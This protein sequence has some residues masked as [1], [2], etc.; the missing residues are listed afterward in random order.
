MPTV[1]DAPP[2]SEA[3]ANV[4]RGASLR[5]GSEKILQAGIED[6]LTKAGFPVR[7]EVILAPKDRIDFLVGGVGIE[8][9][10]G[11]TLNDAIRQLHRYAASDKVSELLLVTSRLLL[12]RVP[13]ELDGKPVYAVY[14][15]APF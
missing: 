7:R 6:A 14:V 8:V 15:G 3:I 12:A 13:S 2:G 5:F 11:G 9:K 4:L 10:I 1:N